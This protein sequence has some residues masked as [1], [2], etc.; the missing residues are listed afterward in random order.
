MRSLPPDPPLHSSAAPAARPFRTERA[1]AGIPSVVQVG[2]LQTN[3]KLDM[4][5]WLNGTLVHVERRKMYGSFSLKLNLRQ[6]P[7]DSHNIEMNVSPSP[8]E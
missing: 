3:M 2:E 8:D 7:F 6:F 5:D 1:C 4:V